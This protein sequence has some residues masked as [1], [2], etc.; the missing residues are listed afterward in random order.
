M[1][2]KAGQYK[3][4][5]KR[6]SL[7]LP[8]FDYHSPHTYHITW[9]T[10]RRKPLLAHSDLTSAL[11][12]MLPL[13]AESADIVLYAYCFMPDHVHLLLR[14]G[15]GKDVTSFVQTYKEK[16]TRTYWK[17]GGRGRLWQRGFYDHILR[18]EE[19][20]QHVTRYIL[21][22]PVRKGIANSFVDY[23]FSGSAVF[24]KNVL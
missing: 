11:I 20:L 10:F 1:T 5:G 6:R 23:P 17:K 18:S 24:D 15:Q 8:A 14:P 4:Y 2:G 21:E 7:R 22:N 9:G 19:N 12:N 16:T 3:T 13:T